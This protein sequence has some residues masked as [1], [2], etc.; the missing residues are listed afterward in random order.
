M[1]KE[2]KRF[3][4]DC[5][6]AD[7]EDRFNK[8]EIAAAH[9]QLDD[10][11]FLN[12]FA[13]D[14]DL[15]LLISLDEYD[16]SKTKI[17]EAFGLKLLLENVP[18]LTNKHNTRYLP[19]LKEHYPQFFQG[20][21]DN[22]SV[23]AQ[24]A[25]LPC[26]MRP[27]NDDE[28]A[29]ELDGEYGY[30]NTP[31]ITAQPYV[32]TKNG[33]SLKTNYKA[34]R[35][36]MRKKHMTFEPVTPELIAL[37]QRESTSASAALVNPLFAYIG[38]ANETYAGMAFVVVNNTF[39]CVKDGSHEAWCLGSECNVCRHYKTMQKWVGQVLPALLFPFTTNN[40]LVVYRGDDMDI[41]TDRFVVRGFLS[42]SLSVVT[43][44]GFR[45]RRRMKIIIPAGTPFMPVIATHRDQ[46]EIALLPGTE[47]KKVRQ[48]ACKNS[49]VFTEYV[50]DKGPPQ[51][52][53]LEEATIL[54]AAISYFHNGNLTRD[55]P[56]K[57]EQRE[58]IYNLVNSK[59]GGD[60]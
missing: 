17:R 7:A 50:V 36:T 24:N 26:S 33:A 1:T 12:R 43:T 58:F 60:W 6:M 52:S 54:R 20:L 48:I 41:S 3:A 28:F 49:T 59:Y 11:E 31:E 9:D 44:E 40:E 53:T 51:L 55:V 25:L 4:M 35:S 21:V 16:D 38:G 10:S 39:R 30:D 19:V 29:A 5:L 15:P 13:M 2:D 23:Y 34:I 46:A 47:L 56:T 45:G 22:K 32:D 37:L 18:R 14:K 8:S 57:R 27:C 42:T